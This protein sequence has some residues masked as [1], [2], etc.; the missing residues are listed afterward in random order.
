VVSSRR[1]SPRQVQV[2]GRLVAGES[3]SR[4]DS[5]LRV[6][7][8]A[9]RNRGLVVT[10]RQ[11]GGG[12]VVELTEVGREAAST[13]RV[14]ERLPRPQGRARATSQPGVTEPERIKPGVVSSVLSDEDQAPPARGR[15]LTQSRKRDSVRSTVVQA[16]RAALRAGPSD[17]R[18]MLHT[19]ADGVVPV[20]VS[21][22]QVP[23]AVALVD[24]I[25]RTAERRGMT[26][27]LVPEPGQQW[28]VRR[29]V[30][31]IVY[32]DLSFGFTVSESATR[33]ANPQAGTAWAQRRWLYTSTGRLQV[34]L[35]HD[36]TRGVA[37]AR[38][39]FADGASRTVEEKAG[40]L[41]DEIER[42][43]RAEHARVLGEHRLDELYREER[44]G[45]VLRAR[46]RHWDDLRAAAAME[47]AAAWET[48][49]RLRAF[50]DEMRTRG[51]SG[52]DGWLD[53]IAGH[54]DRLDPPDRV[55]REPSLPESP[56]E[57]SDLAAYLKRWPT[58][59]PP[60]WSPP[61]ESAKS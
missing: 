51:A 34:K 47:Q 15:A 2:L 3:V 11:T 22:A 10:P 29:R 38:G 40:E 19:T 17:E 27:A 8:Y 4:A 39:T 24:V 28:G 56:T 5:D 46:D 59:R 55:P 49:Q 25:L 12:W 35:G 16:T 60:W 52:E 42:R 13:G 36:H 21:R 32:Q 6:T 57:W 1:L 54:A 7:V 37:N 58:A 18:G 9:L 43:A 53:W 23:R 61:A 44:A 33:A 20:A 26:V 48:A 50:A 41:L 30:V 45:E 31:R 14:P